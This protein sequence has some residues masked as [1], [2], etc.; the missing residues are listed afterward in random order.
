MNKQAVAVLALVISIALTVAVAIFIS[1]DDP[2]VAVTTRYPAE[3]Q[4]CAGTIPQLGL[5]EYK[6]GHGLWVTVSFI[7]ED[8]DA[9]LWRDG[10]EFA[11]MEG[12][13][14]DS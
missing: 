8:G 4:I 11:R 5:T 1:G 14:C 9:V 3:A 12:D 10:E 13:W 2:V 6:N 7:D